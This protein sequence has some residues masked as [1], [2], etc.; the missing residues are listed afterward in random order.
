M[1]YFNTNFSKVQRKNICN[2]SLFS[3]ESFFFFFFAVISVFFS[4]LSTFYMCC[5]DTSGL[6]AALLIP[7][8][9][10]KQKRNKPHNFMKQEAKASMHIILKRPFQTVS[11]V[12]KMLHS[13]SVTDLPF[14]KF[15]H[16]WS[17]WILLMW[18]STKSSPSHRRRL[19]LYRRMSTEIFFFKRKE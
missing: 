6:R 2:S 10:W 7:R 8:G 9:I 19:F 12:A 5:R 18:C 4:S 11:W 1:Q 3:C 17:G 15:Q 16:S 14:V 13:Y